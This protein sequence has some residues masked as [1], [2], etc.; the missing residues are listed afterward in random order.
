MDTN[1]TQTA[2]GDAPEV[3]TDNPFRAD[4]QAKVA[5]L[6]AMAAQFPDV[7]DPRPL[8]KAEVALARKTSISFLEKSALFIEASP[9]LGGALSD[10]ASVR[11]AASTELAYGGVIDE[12]SS[13]IRRVQTF[14]LR[15]KLKAAKVGRALYRVGKGLVTSDQGDGLRPHVEEMGKTLNRR[16]KPKRAAPPAGPVSAAEKKA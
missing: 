7:G 15:R 6:R 10:A 13:L 11:E 3:P 4:A 14:I 12:A 5:A 16:R 1:Q 9:T 2:A 8:T